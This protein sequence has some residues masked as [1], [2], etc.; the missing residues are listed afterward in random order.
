MR[1]NVWLTLGG[2]VLILSACS[3]DVDNS[4]RCEG[5]VPDGTLSTACGTSQCVGGQLYDCTSAN[6]ATPT[7]RACDST[8]CS[9]P[10]GQ[11]VNQPC[12]TSNGIDACISGLFCAALDGHTTASCYFEM[13]RA[14][15]TSCTA[16]DQCVSM[17][18]NTTVGACRYEGLNCD[19]AIGC[20]PAGGMARACVSGSGGTNC[21]AVGDGS[22]NAVCMADSDCDAGLACDSAGRCVL[23]VSRSCTQDSECPMGFCFTT[24]V[25]TGGGNHH[26]FC[27]SPCN[28]TGGCPE[29]FACLNTVG[30]SGCARQCTAP[31]D[32][33]N[34]EVGCASLSAGIT[35]CYVC[36]TD[37]DCQSGLTCTR[38]T[39]GGG[40]CHP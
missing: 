3:T 10:A 30:G 32:C 11:S 19:R 27:T 35:F 39:S 21:L 14:D 36:H 9:Y 31:T 29:N 13:S 26:G 34:Q 37:A 25:D 7:G 15:G 20:A 4:C 8:P 5:S 18:C 1:T 33:P 17:S 28:G 12:C 2:C 22:Y 16:D 24:S 6:A 23:D 38:G 40:Y